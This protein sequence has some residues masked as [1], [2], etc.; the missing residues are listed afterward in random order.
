MASSTRWLVVT[1][2]VV[3]VV[4]VLAIAIVG[5]R[6]PADL[7]PGSPEAVVQAYLRGVVDGERAAIRDSLTEELREDCEREGGERLPLAG[8]ESAFEADLLETRE[9]D[10]DTVEVRVRITEFAGEPP[11]G[12]GGYDHTEAFVLE[13]TDGRWGIAEAPWPYDLCLPG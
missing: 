4:A 12:G 2:T 10:D 5:T 1:V 11:F 8:E 13:R 3:A 6:Q 9:V 7:P